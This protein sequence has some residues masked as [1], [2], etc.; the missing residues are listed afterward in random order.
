MRSTIQRR[1][2][3]AGRRDRLAGRRDRPVDRDRRIEHPC[4][5]H[6]TSFVPGPSHWHSKQPL[7]KKRETLNW[8]ERRLETLRAASPLN[9]AVLGK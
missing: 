1:D 6:T 4:C 8:E 7:S 5:T 2:R 3:L 9:G